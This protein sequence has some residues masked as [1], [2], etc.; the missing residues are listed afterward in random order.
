[1]EKTESPGEIEGSFQLVC[2]GWEGCCSQEK[3][4]G[5]VFR[6]VENTVG[7]NIKVDFCSCYLFASSLAQQPPLE[8]MPAALEQPLSLR[9]RQPRQVAQVCTGIN[10]GQCSRQRGIA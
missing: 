6:V 1:M 10:S 4:Q 8:H 9:Y 3:G 2:V 5:T 7:K